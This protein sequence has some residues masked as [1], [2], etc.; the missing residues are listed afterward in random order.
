[1]SSLHLVDDFPSESSDPTEN[2]S[3]LEI[4]KNYCLSLFSG[5]SDEALIRL[6]SDF[7]RFNSSKHS[8]CLLSQEII[9][10]KCCGQLC[11]LYHTRYLTFLRN[12]AYFQK[13]NNSVS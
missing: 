2:I 6:D 9:S 7:V 13:T 12:I 10:S 11:V 5:E 3:S 1:M 8:K 4:L